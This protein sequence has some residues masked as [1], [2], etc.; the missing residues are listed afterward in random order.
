M[1]TRFFDALKDGEVGGL[2]DLLAADVQL[3]GD[4][5]GKAPQLPHTVAGA[6]NVARLLQFFVASLMTV[7]VTVD[8][9]VEQREINRQP[10]AIFRDRDGKIVQTMSLDIL[11][12]R[13]Q[14]VR[15]VLNPDKLSHLGPVGDAWALDRELKDARRQSS[16][17]TR[18]GR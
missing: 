5:G 18:P 12:G 4:G 2:R 11:D 14:T 15:G 17:H 10:C 13:I 6:V 9:S 7:D 1:A 3:V 16:R 8:V